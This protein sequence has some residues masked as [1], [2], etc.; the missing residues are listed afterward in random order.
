[1][2]AVAGQGVRPTDLTAGAVLYRTRRPLSVW[3]C[4][5]YLVITHTLGLSG[6][7]RQRQL[8]LA[9]PHHGR[10]KLHDLRLA[11]RVGVSAVGP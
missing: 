7:Q 1:M 10:S 9:P 11:V 6:A 5:T 8:D 2:E 4:A 3:F